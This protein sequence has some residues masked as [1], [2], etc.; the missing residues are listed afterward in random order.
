MVFG[1]LL[2]QLVPWARGRKGTLLVLGSANVDERLSFLIFFF[3]FFIFFFF[4]FQNF[5]KKKFFD[6]F[7]FFFDFFPLFFPEF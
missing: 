4:F 6:F 3:F 7:F 5:K 1:Y 2:A